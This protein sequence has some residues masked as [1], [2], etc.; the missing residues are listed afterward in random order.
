MNTREGV[1]EV[2]VPRRR[3]VRVR[4]EGYVVVFGDSCFLWWR[5]RSEL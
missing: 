4:R 1:L 3:G 2:W 5:G